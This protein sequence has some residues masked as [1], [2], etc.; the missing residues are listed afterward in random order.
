V[1][2]TQPFSVIRFSSSER[3]RTENTECCAQRCLCS[4]TVLGLTTENGERKTLHNEKPQGSRSPLGVFPA[5]PRALQ[6]SGPLIRT[7]VRTCPSEPHR[8]RPMRWD[9]S[10]EHPEVFSSEPDPSPSRLPGLKPAVSGFPS[11]PLPGFPG[12]GC[13]GSPLGSDPNVAHCE[14]PCKPDQCLIFADHESFS[15]PPGTVAKCISFGPRSC[16]CP[17]SLWH[18]RVLDH[19]AG[20][21]GGNIDH[22]RWVARIRRRPARQWPRPVPIRGQEWSCY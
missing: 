7:E 14:R 20:N 22:R 18:C 4:V 3:I 11:T 1:K 8:P 5:F 16:C 19:T 13:L 21:A 2:A 10:P 9:R 6:P 15:R 17:P 12:C